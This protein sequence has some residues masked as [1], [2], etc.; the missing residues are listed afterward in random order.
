MSKNIVISI[1]F[2][3]SLL[4]CGGGGGSDSSNNIGGNIS[5]EIETTDPTAL[6]APTKI[7]DWIT[8]AHLS[9][10]NYPHSSPIH[11]SYFMPVGE[12]NPALHSFSGK[13]SITNGKL[14]GNFNEFTIFP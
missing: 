1:M 12:S 14:I 8:A 7:R 9:D 3:F 6:S 11:N 2:L 13:I 5:N 4:A 10:V